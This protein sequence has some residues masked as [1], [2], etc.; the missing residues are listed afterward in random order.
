MFN[1]K[2]ALKDNCVII[3]LTYMSN[4]STHFNVDAATFINFETNSV[5]GEKCSNV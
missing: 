1:S 4:V 3:Q 5:S 2:S